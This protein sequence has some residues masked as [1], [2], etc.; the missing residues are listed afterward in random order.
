MR[1]DRDSS[2]CRLYA[3][4]PF[5]H[6]FL[7]S[8]SSVTLPGTLFTIPAFQQAVSSPL[9]FTCLQTDTHYQHTLTH[10]SS[11]LALPDSGMRRSGDRNNNH[12]FVSCNAGIQDDR[13]MWIKKKRGGGGGEA[14]GMGMLGEGGRGGVEG[15]RAEGGK[16]V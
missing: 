3:P 12:G 15:K 13:V 7:V 8:L 16:D 5:S 9:V 2:Q 4:L 1:D 11:V 14:R 10:N 6:L